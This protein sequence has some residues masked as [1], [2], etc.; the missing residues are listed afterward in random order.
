MHMYG[1]K[2]LLMTDADLHCYLLDVADYISRSFKE[3]N[4]EPTLEEFSNYLSSLIEEHFAELVEKEIETIVYQP[5][6]DSSKTVIISTPE[7]FFKLIERKYNIEDIYR[8][9][10]W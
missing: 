2:A 10:I 1:N 9:F 6:D 5:S 8:E 3:E 4:H 7:Q